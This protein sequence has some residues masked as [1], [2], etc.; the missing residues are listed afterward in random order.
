[1][2]FGYGRIHGTLG[3]LSMGRFLNVNRFYSG[4]LKSSQPS[5]S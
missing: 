5:T 1:M 3:V 4:Q 2:L